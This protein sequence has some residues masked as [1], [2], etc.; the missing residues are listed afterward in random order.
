MVG[1]IAY[2]GVSDT[3][4]QRRTKQDASDAEEAE[5]QVPT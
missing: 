4:A 5:M 2:A 1:L 3:G